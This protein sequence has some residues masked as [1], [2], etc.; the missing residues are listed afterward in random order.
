MA[1]KVKLGIIGTSGW[2]DLIYLSKLQGDPL[3]EV[4]A[5]CGRNQTRLDE[6]AKAVRHR[7]DLH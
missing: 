2:T 6:L 3:V 4:A 7:Q 1:D 5:I